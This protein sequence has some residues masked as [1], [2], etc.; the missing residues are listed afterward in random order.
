MRLKRNHK[1]LLSSLMIIV[2]WFMI[3]IGYTTKVNLLQHLFL[4]GV[5]FVS[6]GIMMFILAF[7]SK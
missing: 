1:I 4:F 3:G 2:S 6:V 7:N 5:L